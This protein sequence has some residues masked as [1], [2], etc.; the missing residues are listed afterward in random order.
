VSILVRPARPDDVAAMS[1]VLIASITELCGADHHHDADRI[2]S[3]TANKTPQGVAAMLAQD[4]T[5]LFVAKVDGEVAAVG[6]TSAGGQITLNYVA[7]AFRFRGISTALLAHMEADLLACGWSEGQLKSTAT[8]LDFYR[9]RGWMQHEE[10]RRGR[11][12]DSVAMHKQL[13]RTG[14]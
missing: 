2:A 8:A 9:S 11:F 4:G 6:A 5:T 14:R 7:P 10:P 13:V 12:I 3:W 1:A